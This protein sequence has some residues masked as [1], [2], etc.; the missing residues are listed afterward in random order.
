[1]G[2]K[3][4]FLNGGVLGA[5]RGFDHEEEGRPYGFREFNEDAPKAKREVSMTMSALQGLKSEIVNL[6]EED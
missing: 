1:M 2:L 4:F 3:D 5:M 6:I